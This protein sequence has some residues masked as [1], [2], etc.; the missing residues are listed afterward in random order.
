ML[1]VE[2]DP[3]VLDTALVSLSSLG[4]RTVIARSGPE[5]LDI[6]NGNEPV[7]LLFTDVVLPGGLNGVEVAHYA[8]NIRPGLRIL[9]TTGYRGLSD[10]GAVQIDEH[11]PMLRKPYR[12]P[13]LAKKLEEVLR[14]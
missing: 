14:S 9:L 2:D 13:E 8:A 6:L 1:V 3:H 7:D 11:L 4:Y 12:R 5:A 10:T